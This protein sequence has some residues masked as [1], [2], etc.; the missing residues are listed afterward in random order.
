MPFGPGTYGGGMG[1]GQRPMMNA[2]Q[3]RQAQAMT[4]EQLAASLAAGQPKLGA[5]MMPTP[6]GYTPTPTGYTPT[7]TP[8]LPPRVGAPVGTAPG[9]MPMPGYGQVPGQLPPQ[10]APQAQ[11]Q[12]MAL[13]Q[14]MR[15]PAM[16]RRQQM[17][18]LLAARKGGMQQG[19][20]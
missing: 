4:Q 1:Y 5:T 12:R 17:M 10:A 9:P 15:D 14:A 16:A 8:G 20:R 13:L 6:T 18:A 2:L 7:P 11:A 19:T 3:N